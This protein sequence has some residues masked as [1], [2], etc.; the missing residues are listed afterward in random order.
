MFDSFHVEVDKEDV[1]S[2]F[3]LLVCLLLFILHFGVDLPCEHVLINRVRCQSF[4]RLPLLYGLFFS[5]YFSVIIV[6]RK[7]LG[8]RH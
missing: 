4:P 3:H 1:I 7:V 2:G 5:F 8:L 6:Y